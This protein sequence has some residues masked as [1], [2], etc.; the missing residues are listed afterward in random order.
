YI[1]NG[2]HRGWMYNSSPFLIPYILD[3]ILE[4]E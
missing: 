1:A 3:R 2:G 4:G